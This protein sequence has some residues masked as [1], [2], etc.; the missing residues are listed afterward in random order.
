MTAVASSTPV[1]MS[2]KIHTN[3]TQTEESKHAGNWPNEAGVSQRMQYF[4]IHC[5]SNCSLLTKFNASIEVREP[6]ELVV[7][8]FI[9]PA[10]AGTLYR[11]GPGHYQIPDTPIGTFK[12]THWFGTLSGSRNT[13]Y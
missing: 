4:N 1:A 7:Q 6:K 3:G 9:P 2:E 11:T 13:L 8:G 12:A 5:L 10:V